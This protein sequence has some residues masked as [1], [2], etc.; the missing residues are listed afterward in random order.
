LDLDEV[1]EP[2][3][4]E[5][6][7]PVAAFAS[8]AGYEAPAGDWSDSSLVRVD[9]EIQTPTVSQSAITEEFHRP[10]IDVPQEFGAE[11]V[12]RDGPIAEEQAR[13]Q[14]GGPG[15][16][17]PSLERLSP[18]II[19]A[20]ARRVVEHLSEKVV[21]EI[22]WEVVPQLAELMIKRQLEEKNS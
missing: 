1:P 17:E 11:P 12:L 10:G 15:A 13:P 4:T 22:A 8:T 20:I 6:A 3:P 14:P 18:E 5:S 2:A 7:L 9:D 21:K 19:D 16:S